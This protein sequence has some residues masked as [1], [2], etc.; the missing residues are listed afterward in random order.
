MKILIVDDIE[1]NRKL[2]HVTL[3]AEG[4]T[5]FDAADGVEALKALD[6][7]AVEAIISDILMPNMDGYRLCHE[8]RK[9]ERW[10]EIPFIFYTSSYLSP[11]DEKLALDLGADKFLRK[12][13]SV[14]EIL[15]ALRQV[16]NLPRPKGR[17]A[18]LAMDEVTVLKEY[19]ERLIA[20]LEEK[21]LELQE[22][23]E[24]FRQ[25]AETIHEVFWLGDK[26]LSK[27]LYIS[28]ACQHVLGR[29]CSSVYEQPLSFFQAAH[30]DDQERVVAALQRQKQG[31]E[32]DEEFRIIH[33]DGSIRWVRN[34]TYAVMNAGGEFYRIAGI[35]SDITDRKEAESKSLLQATALNATAN[36]ILITDS[37][38]IIQ[39]VNPAF[40]DLTGYSALEAIGKTPRILK[41]GK[42]ELAFYRDFWKTILSGNIWRGEFTNRHKD[43]SL[44]CDEHAVTPVHSAGGA[45]THFVGIMNDVTER[46]NA[47]KELRRQSEELARSNSELKRFNRAAV[48]RELRMVELKQ[49]VNGLSEKAGEAAPYE[50]SFL[51]KPAA[52]NDGEA[53]SGSDPV[54]AAARETLTQ[55]GPKEVGP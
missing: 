1:T 3:E 10:R 21:N 45:I 24:R 25:L 17:P 13:A 20:K 39:W 30:P 23:Q 14:Q 29:N 6:R 41:S 38:G 48:G 40:T 47:E 19:S 55:S 43:G 9:S 46:R 7:Q 26:D 31:E 18:G 42:H 16:A 11:A 5:V 50:L 51:P 34:R 49:Q 44:Y 8:L 33:P 32:T 28:P 37:K 54:L 36:A 12:P 2:L 52:S 35:A 4:H 27:I 15:D 53:S 22:N